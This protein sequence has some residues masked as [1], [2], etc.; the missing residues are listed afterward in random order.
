MKCLP[1]SKIPASNGIILHDWHAEVLTIRSLNRYLLDECRRLVGEGGVSDILERNEQAPIARATRTTSPPFRIKGNIKLHMY[2]SEAPC[3]LVHPMTPRTCAHKFPGG[4]A[5]M[6]LTMTAQDD[7]TAWEDPASIPVGAES[8]EQALVGREFFSRLGVVRRKP[9]RRDSPPTLSK[10]CSDK[11]ALKQCT[12]LLSSISSLFVDPENA[13]IDTLIVPAS[14]YTEVGYERSFSRRGRLKCLDG[15]SGLGGY[16]FRPFGIETTAVEFSF[17]R[18]MVAERW[19]KISPSTVGAA[20][21]SSGFEE[22]IVGGVLQGRRQSEAKAASRMSRRQMWMA[23][24]DLA[25]QLGD[26]HLD[27]QSAVGKKAY[28]DVKKGSLLAAR[29]QVTASVR[30]EALSGWVQNQGDSDFRLDLLES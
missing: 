7:A 5:S 1:A 15:W 29:S 25:G 6:E 8:T 20:W 18:K 3:K 23:A 2:C 11:L 22:T 30:N 24:K 12:S 21:L 13:Y 26:G 4:D 28:A 9:G 19:A 17:S 10:S 16:S 27:I 14:Q